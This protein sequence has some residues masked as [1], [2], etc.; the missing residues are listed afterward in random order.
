MSPSAAAT[1]VSGVEYVQCPCCDYLGEVDVELEDV[2][3]AIAVGR[4]REA[5]RDHVLWTHYQSGDWGRAP[6]GQV[7]VALMEQIG[8]LE[9]E[10][11]QRAFRRAWKAET[12]RPSWFDRFGVIW[13]WS[14]A[15][16]I[17]GSLEARQDSWYPWAFAALV[18]LLV[19]PLAS[20]IGFRRAWKGHPTQKELRGT[21]G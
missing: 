8:V 3:D 11:A 6:N 20:Y 1:I 15:A 18:V 10:E 21:R 2:G 16:F 12:P 17:W 9:P 5:L 13:A 7:A 4:V 19:W 14:T